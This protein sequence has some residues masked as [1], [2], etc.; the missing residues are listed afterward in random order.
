[1]CPRQISDGAR[2]RQSAYSVISRGTILHA[3]TFH[4]VHRLRSYNFVAKLYIIP[5]IDVQLKIVL[6]K[7]PKKT[8]EILWIFTEIVEN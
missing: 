8:R 6:K 5:T 4:A 3:T 2:N 1:L 7:S